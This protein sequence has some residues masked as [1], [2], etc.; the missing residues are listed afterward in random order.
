MKR[1]YNIPEVAIDLLM[2]TSGSTRGDALHWIYQTAEAA[3]VDHL[4][5]NP[6]RMDR[7]DVR[8]HSNKGYTYPGVKNKL[9][10]VVNY[11]P[12]G[13]HRN[14]RHESYFHIR[15]SMATKTVVLTDQELKDAVAES[16]LLSAN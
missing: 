12:V 7:A 10:F 2:K 3:I 14:V 6:R 4:Q 5:K 15:V 1:I 13:D 8:T 9:R 16:C 11:H